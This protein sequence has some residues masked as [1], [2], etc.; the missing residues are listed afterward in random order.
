MNCHESKEEKLLRIEKMKKFQY[1]YFLVNNFI[2]IFFHFYQ[3]PVKVQMIQIR[4]EN[5]SQNRGT[6]S[7]CTM[8]T[9]NDTTAKFN[10]LV[11]FHPMSFENWPIRSH[12]SIP[13][14]FLDE[15]NLGS[16]LFY[17]PFRNWLKFFACMWKY[18][19]V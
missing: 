7:E 16:F 10:L 14:A 13:L 2:N 3:F 6:S 11:W 1:I 8:N 9:S 12:F 5:N 15:I 17:K 4:I 18:H 19:Q